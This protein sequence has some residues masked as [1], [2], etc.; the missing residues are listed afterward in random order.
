MTSEI[1]PVAFK[2][3]VPKEQKNGIFG[4]EQELLDNPQQPITAVVTFRVDDIIDKE[5]TGERY[6]IVEID[7]IEPIFGDEAIASAKALQQAAYKTRTAGNQ[8]LIDDEADADE[9]AADEPGGDEEPE[10][11]G[12]TDDEQAEADGAE[13]FMA[14]TPDWAA[15]A[16]QQD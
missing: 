9:A 1:K 13:P 15:A 5:L 16:R 7:H 8:L 3:G 14:P 12:V 2:R 11:T 6:P 10:D 4:L